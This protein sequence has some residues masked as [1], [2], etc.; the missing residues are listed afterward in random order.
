MIAL[1]RDS[2]LAGLRSCF[3]LTFMIA[4]P[5]DDLLK[6]NLILSFI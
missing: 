5:E 1:K 6:D 2:N 3:M 4:L